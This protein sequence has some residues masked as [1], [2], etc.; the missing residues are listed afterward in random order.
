VQSY[1]SQFVFSEEDKLL[2]TFAAKHI[3][4]AI[5]RMQARS[6]LTNLAL[7]DSLTQLPN[8]ILF[9]DRLDRALIDLD[10]NQHAIVALLFLD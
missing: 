4:N 7:H 10:R 9:N 1:N 3:R 5:E 6:E 8:R 2:L